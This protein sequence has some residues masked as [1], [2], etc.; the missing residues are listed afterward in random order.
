MSPPAGAPPDPG[1]GFYPHIPC[2]AGEGFC[3]DSCLFTG[4]SR[5]TPGSHSPAWTL[6]TVWD[7]SGAAQLIGILTII[8]TRPL[9]SLYH[10]FTV[11]SA[12]IFECSINSFC[13]PFSDVHC[14]VHMHVSCQCTC[15]CGHMSMKVHVWGIQ[16]CVSVL[17]IW[18]CTC[19]HACETRGQCWPLTLRCLLVKQTR[20]VG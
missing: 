16:V 8:L 14:C 6:G 11:A 18:A 7:G 5:N 15:V 10:S 1:H 17:C 13:F 4:S 12:M 9:C 19:V 3:V 20:A 2:R